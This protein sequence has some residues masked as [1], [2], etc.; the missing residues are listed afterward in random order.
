MY[1]E[2][3]YIYTYLKREKRDF[4]SERERENKYILL[5]SIYICVYLE[6]KKRDYIYIYVF[7]CA[8]A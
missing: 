6:R 4:L 5:E 7:S 1:L 2:R 8:R 3:V